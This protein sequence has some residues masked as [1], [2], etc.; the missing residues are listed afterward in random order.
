MLLKSSQ[1][2][3]ISFPNFFI[4]STSYIMSTFRTAFSSKNVRDDIHICLEI[5]DDIKAVHFRSS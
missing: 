4:D 3:D 1:I 5:A 2:V